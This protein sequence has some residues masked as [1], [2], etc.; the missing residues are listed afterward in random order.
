MLGR[1]N[2]FHGLGSLN[3]VYKTGKTVRGPMFSTK[4]APNNKKQNFRFAVVVSKKVHKSAV[5]R[6]LIRRK[7]YGVARQ[8]KIVEP[9]D[10][11]ITIFSEKLLEQSAEQIKKDLEKQLK[12]AGII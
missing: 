5:K 10:I 8:F 2:R 7:I 12:Q 4:F 6:N 9:F 1:K 3:Y 11:V